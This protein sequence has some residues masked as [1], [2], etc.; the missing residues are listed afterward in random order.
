MKTSLGGGSLGSYYL[1]YNIISDFMTQANFFTRS[2]KSLI[3]G[4]TDSSL[5][6]DEFKDLNVTSWQKGS[7]GE[8]Q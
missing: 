2:W 1:L 6:Y 8:M 3:A 4:N 7:W 5:S